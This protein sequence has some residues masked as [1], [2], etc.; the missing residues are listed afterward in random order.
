[1]IVLN[2]AEAADEL[3]MNRSKNYSG[4]SAP[5][6]GHDIL[7]DGQRIVFLPYG[8]EW[9]VRPCPGMCDQMYLDTDR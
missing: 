2:T 6:V 4:R 7:S 5:H 3:F 1:M 9:K 8:K